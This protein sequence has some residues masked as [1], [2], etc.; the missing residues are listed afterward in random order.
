YQSSPRFIKATAHPLGHPAIECK[1]IETNEASLLHEW[2]LATCDA[3]VERVDA[4]AQVARRRVDVEPSRF[5][6]RSS[7]LSRFQCHDRAPQHSR[8]VV[9]GEVPRRSAYGRR[10]RRSREPPR[11]KRLDMTTRATRACMTSRRIAV[12]G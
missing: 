6:Y 8:A 9:V 12:V 11:C 10:R 4:H 5:E 1:A 7:G 2:D 3:V